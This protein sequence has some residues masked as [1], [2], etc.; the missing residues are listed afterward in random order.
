MAPPCIVP[1]NAYNN[2]PLPD[3]IDDSVHVYGQGYC[4]IMY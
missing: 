2:R 3:G 1:V 4:C